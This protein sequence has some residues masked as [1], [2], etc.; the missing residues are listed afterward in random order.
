MTRWAGV[1]VGTNNVVAELA[2]MV[3]LLLHHMSYVPI[4]RY[5]LNVERLGR[6]LQL[7]LDVAYQGE[8]ARQPVDP[9]PYRAA[10][11]Y[12]AGRWPQ[13]ARSRSDHC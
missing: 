11:T 3:V 10:R 9:A 5:A 4:C 1:V 12:I 8:L 6:V 13:Y 2:P 7:L